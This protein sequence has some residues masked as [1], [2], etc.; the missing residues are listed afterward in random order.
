MKLMREQ[1]EDI[2]NFSSY[3]FDINNVGDL[4]RIF[5]EQQQK[6][7]SIPKFDSNVAIQVSTHVQTVG[8]PWPESNLTYTPLEKQ[9]TAEAQGLMADCEEWRIIQAKTHEENIQLQNLVI[10]KERFKDAL[11]ADFT[12]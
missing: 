3:I 12:Q 4:V 1:L 6:R 7:K 10:E 8:E 9:L 11:K 2:P 5:A